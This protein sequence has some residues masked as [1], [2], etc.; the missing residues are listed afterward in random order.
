MIF[1]LLGTPTDEQIN[2]FPAPGTQKFLKSLKKQPSKKLESLFP[3]VSPI[4][5]DLLKK[6]LSFDQNKRITVE[7]AL[8]HPFLEYLHCEEDEIIRKP[9]EMADFEFEQYNLTIE[10]LKDMIYEEILLYHFPSQ[11]K[12]YDQRKKAGKSIIDHILLAETNK[13]VNSLFKL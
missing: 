11:M 5:L 3:D 9:V 1:E 10:Q 7:Q 13:L 6:M 12:E 2:A 4:G 8:D